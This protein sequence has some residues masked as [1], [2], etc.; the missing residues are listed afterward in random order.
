MENWKDIQGY[1]GRYQVSNLGRVRSLDKESICVEKKSSV[2]EPRTFIMKTKGRI[3]KPSYR[4][5]YLRVQLGRYG[6]TYFIHRLVAQ[7][8][9]P[10]PEN[11]EQ[12]NHINLIRDDNRVENLEWT[13]ASENV[14]HG[15]YTRKYQVHEIKVI[16]N[17]IIYTFQSQNEAKRAGVAAISR[18]VKG[19]Q[20]ETNG[21]RLYQ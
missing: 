2:R 18:L 15:H 9:I 17:G 10:N 14:I 7:A 19:T 4:D 11:K 5:G 16:K 13:T 21:F 3:M 1:E 6:G 12:V 20:L 8:F